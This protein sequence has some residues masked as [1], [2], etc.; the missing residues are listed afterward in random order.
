M[1]KFTAVL[2]AI[3]LAASLTACVN[4]AAPASEAP[5]AAQQPEEGAPEVTGSMLAEYPMLTNL[6]LDGTLQ[7][8]MYAGKKIVVA[9]STGDYETCLKIYSQIFNELT[10]GE[11]EIQAFPDQLFEKTQLGLN[12]GGQFDVVVV[13]IAFVHSYGY[14][15]LL[16]DLRDMLNTTASPGY[17]VDDFLAGLY[18]T[19][20]KY[21]GM[22]LAFPFKPDSQ[23]LFYRK[24]LFEDDAVKS[25]FQSKY[26]RELTVPVTPEEMLEVA[27]FFT[28]SIN[29]DS[30][31]DYGFSATMLKGSSRFIW[32][33]R[34]GY[35][36]GK[37]VDDNFEPGFIN[38]SGEKA[39]QFQADLCK[40]APSD[41]LTFD[42][43]TGNTFF[44]QGNAAMMEQWPGLYLT[45]NQ[46]SSPTKGKVGYAV[47]PGQSPTL[48]GW[49]M[50][51]AADSPEQEMAFKFCEM[52]TSKDGE[53][54]KIPY[55]MDPCRR[56]NYERDIIKEI[57][58][59]ALYTALMENLAAASQLADTDI[60]YI[61]AQV[62]DI[63]ETAIQAVLTGELGIPDAVQQM[64]DQFR[65]AVESVRSEL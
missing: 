55:T 44:A 63:E 28:K 49:A 34:L 25:Q 31:V 52:V 43:D 10:G 22:T 8:G 51:I 58:D 40:F 1:K 46:D 24:D 21:N 54:I 12:S 9:S 61:S 27:E 38:G 53:Y 17:D 37:E 11:V 42:W 48:G 62:G 14:A 33:N 15:G 3:L 35:Y 65:S 64:A 32:F 29:P 47:C 45:C 23:M 19:Y 41:I 56:S 57:S 59:P 4:T 2:T 7:P 50:A 13:P 6:N 5:A 18:N 36:D 60:P 30:P 26:N 20:A 39:L 16:T